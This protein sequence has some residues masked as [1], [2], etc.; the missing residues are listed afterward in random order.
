M[1]VAVAGCQ[2][3]LIGYHYDSPRF[4]IGIPDTIDI[5]PET[6]GDDN[7]AVLREADARG[8]RRLSLTEIQ[9]WAAARGYGPVDR[10]AV[11]RVTRGE[12]DKVNLPSDFAHAL[13]EAHH[14]YYLWMFEYMDSIDG[15]GDG[16]DVPGT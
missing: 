5:A 12:F 10:L 14:E 1:A 4:Q 15:N 13:R 8:D 7:Y 6:I 16:P 11:L 3:G 2:Q 9:Q